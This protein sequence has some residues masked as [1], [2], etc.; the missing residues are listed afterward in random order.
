[1]DFDKFKI[2]IFDMYAKEEIKVPSFTLVKNAFDG[3]DL[4]KDGI[5]D[6][7]EWGKAFGN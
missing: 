2:L 4:R 7:N 3:I 1:M 6:L 5:K